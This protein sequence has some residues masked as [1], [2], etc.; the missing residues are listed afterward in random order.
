M[1]GVYFELRDDHDHTQAQAGAKVGVSRQAGQK[2][3]QQR[4]EAAS[5]ATGGNTC[6]P[7]AKPKKRDKRTKLDPDETATIAARAA[8]RERTASPR[9][10]AVPTWRPPAAHLAVDRRER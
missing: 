2:W 1:S 6:N 7:L 10:D 4:R 8:V 9:G 5:N 3:E